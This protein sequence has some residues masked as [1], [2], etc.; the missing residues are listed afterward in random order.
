MYESSNELKKLQYQ[1]DAFYM[2]S[3]ESKLTFNS[4]MFQC[5]HYRDENSESDLELVI[6]DDT[7]NPVQ[8]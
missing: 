5:I 7:G 4:D 3:E 1:I 8:T 2:W 6:L